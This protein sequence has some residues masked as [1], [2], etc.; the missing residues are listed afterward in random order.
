MLQLRVISVT[1]SSPRYTFNPA[2]YSNQRANRTAFAS[3][4]AYDRVQSR[5]I[6]EQRRPIGTN[7]EIGNG[8]QAER[9]RKGETKEK[10]QKK[11]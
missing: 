9:K 10:Q 3:R 1:I 6:T 11:A 5:A 2:Q 7:W 4:R 8:T